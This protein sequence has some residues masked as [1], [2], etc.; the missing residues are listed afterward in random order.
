MQIQSSIAAMCVC[1]CA[2]TLAKGLTAVCITHSTIS[3]LKSNICV[4]GRRKNTLEVY[5]RQEHSPNERIYNSIK[6]PNFDYTLNV[7]NDIINGFY[8][9]WEL[10][11]IWAVGYRSQVR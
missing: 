3:K 10:N 4:V 8:V 2:K 9:R 6:R 11:G 5:A 7:K 1:V